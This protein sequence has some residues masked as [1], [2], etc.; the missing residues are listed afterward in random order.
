MKVFYGWWIVAACFFITLYISSTVFFGLTAFFEP[1][2][3][4][5][6]WSYAQVSFASSLR[7]MEMGLFAPFIGYL[8]DR[9]GAR[10]IM[11]LGVFFT[12]AGLMLFSATDSLLWFYV[13]FLLM[14]FGAG[15]CATL[16]SM[17]VI[18]Q[19][20]HRHIGKASGIMASGFGAGGLMIPLFVWLID[21]FDWRTAL[22]ILAGGLWIICVPLTYIV[23]DRPEDI[24]LFPDGR[25]PGQEAATTRK[26]GK[27][28]ELDFRS[29]VKTGTFWYLNI[30][31]FI[32]FLVVTSMVV[33][34]MPYL[35]T[36]GMSRTAAGLIAMSIGLTSIFGRLGFGWLGDL[37]ERKTIMTVAFLLMSAGM[38]V[39]SWGHPSVWLIVL[40]V[41][42]YCPAYGGLMVMRSP[43]LYSYFGRASLG[44]LLGIMLG[45]SSIAGIIGPTFTGLAYDLWRSY[46]QVWLIFAGLLAGAALLS[47]RLQPVPSR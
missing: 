16:V 46:E 2:V 35:G 45:I 4:E 21:Y 31:E 1:L 42:L 37:Y 14:G 5:F 17:T 10:R 30:S 28:I 27:S 39:L 40:F 8:L 6:G 15:G 26:D 20:F 36:L 43:V 7:G 9:F 33:H 47:M 29:A 24:G 19:W 12:G 3:R 32:R 44:K 34:I 18:A 13:A 22:T 11:F 38:F 25:Q 41:V 23:R